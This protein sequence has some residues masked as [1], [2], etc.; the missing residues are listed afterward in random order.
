M[1]KAFSAF[2]GFIAF[3]F[4]IF[5]IL[6]AWSQ[7]D[8]RNTSCYDGGKR[9]NCYVRQTYSRLAGNS[10]YHIIASWSDGDTTEL[11]I[12]TKGSRD[13]TVYGKYNGSEWFPAELS[14]CN[15]DT[16]TAR[17]VKAKWGEGGGTGCI[18]DFIPNY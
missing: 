8:S 12:P 17:Y 18:P 14:F 7:G 6:P 4:S 13:N 1:Q 5:P 11:F 15:I 9:M 16:P 3:I 2:S 10:G